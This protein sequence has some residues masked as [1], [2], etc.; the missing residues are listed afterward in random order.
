MEAARGLG[1]GAAAA[2]MAAAAATAGT[3]LASQ[4]IAPG[5]DRGAVPPPRKVDEVTGWGDEW[6]KDEEGPNKRLLGSPGEDKMGRPDPKQQ[7]RGILQYTHRKGRNGES[8]AV[9]TRT[10]YTPMTRGGQTPERGVPGG[11]GRNV[12]LHDAI[13][14]ADGA[15]RGGGDS[16]KTWNWWNWRRRRRR[17]RRQFPP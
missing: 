17:R 13:S 11:A 6:D 3:E 12:A 16:I 7:S 14:A 5:E 4:A 10:E 15:R 1:L 9:Q 8:Q 2:T